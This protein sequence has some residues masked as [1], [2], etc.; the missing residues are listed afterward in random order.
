MTGIH[1]NDKVTKSI[2]TVPRGM[3]MSDGVIYCSSQIP[4]EA[5]YT[6]NGEGPVTFWAFGMTEDYVPMLGQPIVNFVVKNNST[7]TVTE[8]QAYNRLPAHDSLVIYYGNCNYTNFALDDAYEVVLTNINGTFTCGGTVSG[9]V[10]A[11][12]SAD[13]DTSPTLDKNSIVL[14]AR[15][16]KI[17]KISGYQI[18]DEISI[19]ISI[20]DASGRDNDWS[21][22]VLAIGGHMP[23]MIDGVSTNPTGI[24][25][26]PS[27]IIGYKTDGKVIIIQNDGRQSN[28]S[29]GLNYNYMDDL[30][31]QLGVNTCI[32]LDGGGSSTMIVGD[33]LVNKPSDG[34]ARAVINGIALVSCEER[35]PQGEFEPKVPYKFNSKCLS[36][37]NPQAVNVISSGYGNTTTVTA[38][39]GTLRLTAS[40]DT[41]D[42]YQYY[43]VSS[44]VNTL[45][46]NQYKYIVIKYKTSQNVTTPA[47]ELFLCSGN[48]GGPAAG[49]SITFSHGTAG[50]WNTQIVDL[51]ARTDWSGTI[52]GIRLDYFAGN[53]NK[54]EYM[55]IAYIAFAK[56]AEEAQSYANETAELP[57]VPAE[58]ATISVKANA[59]FKK[60]DGNLIGVPYG[61]TVYD[62]VNGLSA[63]KLE[64]FDENGNSVK[65]QRVENGYTVCSY[66]S[67]LEVYETLTVVMAGDVNDDGYTDNLDASAVLKYDAGI[68][69]M[70]DTQKT[71]GDINGDGCVDNLDA[72]VMLKI[73]AGLM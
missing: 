31:M 64:V 43:S 71:M 6:T 24:G 68:S 38:V 45:N 14:T 70:T 54:G 57:T 22:V 26:Y 62:L 11:V 50:E 3:L 9:T 13:D 66:N 21:K 7:S 16:D 23:L 65:A 12:Y 35:A 61:T 8:T 69:N 32:H 15:G 48:I 44:A 1:S 72:A 52:H 67:V 40:K 47:T 51:T 55:D 28:W 25:N 27:T 4:N 20:S 63:A 49:H 53:A 58:N 46:A 36:F 33:E 37:E 5:T 34:S 18:G 30:M 60:L 19:D 2:L 59:K 39:D 42:P 73:D 41:I 17:E 56:T 29:L 10:S